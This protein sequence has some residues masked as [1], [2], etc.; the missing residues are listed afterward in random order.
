MSHVLLGRHLL[1]DLAQAANSRPRLVS[2]HRSRSDALDTYGPQ[3]DINTAHGP[4]AVPI[5]FR[6]NTARPARQP[7][8]LRNIYNM[9][10]PSPKPTPRAEKA[11]SPTRETKFPWA[12]IKPILDKTAITI[13]SILTNGLIFA[14]IWMVAVFLGWGM[15]WSNHNVHNSPEYAYA[16]GHFV[17]GALYV[18]DCGLL[19]RSVL[20]H[21]W[22]SFRKPK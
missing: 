21:L 19:L 7:G 18:G 6:G 10:K 20:E 16:V 17:E 22:H 13:V 12:A 11:P 8:T 14:T 9:S 1:L 3:E 15:E 4:P 5:R 2:L